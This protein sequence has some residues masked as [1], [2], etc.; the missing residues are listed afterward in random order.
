M[1]HMSAQTLFL[2]LTAELH[3][4]YRLM[5]FD[6]VAVQSATNVLL[7]DSYPTTQSHVAASD[8]HMDPEAGRPELAELE[9]IRSRLRSTTG[10]RCLFMTDFGRLG[11][12][13]Q[14]MQE[15]DTAVVL[16][17][18]KWPFI[19]REEG[20][21]FHFIGHSYIRGVMDGEAV[22]ELEAKGVAPRTFEIR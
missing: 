19:L 10:N 15:G 4:D 17:G 5:N 22:R 8:W 11:F 12:G 7:N 3:N 18:G 1:E 20:K 13:P 2:F 21:C 14:S 16:L 6:E 9:N